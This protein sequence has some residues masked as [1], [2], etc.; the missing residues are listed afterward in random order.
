MSYPVF[1]RNA[2]SDDAT[3]HDL[4]QNHLQN[5]STNIP[6]AS[7]FRR[8]IAKGGEKKGKLSRSTSAAAIHHDIKNKTSVGTCM[9]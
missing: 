7:L 3:T 1:T 9:R 4:E 5:L 8:L 6:V 2:S